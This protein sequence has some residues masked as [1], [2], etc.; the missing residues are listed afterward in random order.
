MNNSFFA[1]I[2][3]IRNAIDTH[4]LV[5]FAG[6]GISI[7]AGVP[8][9]STLIDEMRA[10]I[11]VPPN[12]NDYLRIAQMYFNDRQQKEYLEKIR[13]VLKHTKVKYN[14]IHEEIFDLNPEHILTT[15]YDDLLDQVIK[16]KSLPFSVIRKDHDFP[17]ALNTKH[18]VKI[19]G[20]LSENELVLKEDDYIDYSNEHPLIEGFIKS[21]FVSK[22]VLFIGYGFSDI[23]LK[24]IIQTVRNILGDDFQSAYLLNIDKNFH[25]VQRE[26]LK[27]KGIR[28]IN[29]HDADSKDGEN[30]IT[31]YL[32]GK[33]A[34]NQQYYKESKDLSEKGQTLL[35]FI[36][37]LT[38]Y[39]KFNEKVSSKNLI[40]QMLDSLERFSEFKSLPPN[41]IANLFPFNN[42]KKYVHHYERN[43]ILTKN[44]KL[45][46]LFFNHIGYNEEGEVIYTPPEDLGLT[47]SEIEY[48]QTKL[49]KVIKI[50]N[51]GLI[52][53]IVKENDTPDSFGYKGWSDKY[54]KL[55]VKHPEKCDCLSCCYNRLDLSNVISETAN[56]TIIE[57]SEISSD[58]QVAYSNYNLGNFLLSFHQF[59]EIA[60]K[61][62]ETGRY[63]SY[64]IAKHNSKTLHNLIS[65]FERTIEE[66]DKEEILKKTESI[67]FDKLL[68]QIPYMGEAEYRLL[69]IIRDDDVLKQAGKE[70]R[71]IHRKVIDTYELYKNGGAS[72]HGPNYPTQ[73]NHEL[74]KIKSFYISNHIVADAFTEFR[75]VCNIA[76]EALIICSAIKDEY[77]EKLKEFD[78]LFFET[79]VFYGN[80]TDLKKISEKYNVNSLNFAEKDR[81]KILE[82]TNNFLK[83]FVSNHAFM[84]IVSADD[85]TSVQLKNYFFQ[86]R[87]ADK[88]NN[89]F[90]QLS[91]MLIKI[92]ETGD[93][94]QNLISFL[95]I[96]DFIDNQGL[97]YLSAFISKNHHLFTRENCEA[98]LQKPMKKYGVDRGSKLIYALLQVYEKNKFSLS[99]QKDHLLELAYSKHHNYLFLPD[100]WS[101]STDEIKLLIKQ[102]ITELLNE[103]FN[104][105]LYVNSVVRGVM[106]YDSFFEKYISEINNTKGINGSVEE[107][108]VF[109]NAILFL[110]RMNIPVNQY[111][112]LLTNKT[113]YMDF[114]LDP[115]NYDY[116]GF[117]AE[118][119]TKWDNSIIYGRL[120]KIKGLK[121]EIE[122]AIKQHFDSELAEIY[123]KYFGNI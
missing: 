112:S 43:A 117:K 48:Y 102:R 119:I 42:S 5:V 67:D 19:H 59:E 69:K 98:I 90:L 103:K 70:L 106:P 99:N 110:Y 86:R 22:I 38:N 30:Y 78:L 114:Y 91:G 49:K 123:F 60:N 18:L 7:D 76:L 101:I 109:L 34:L 33:N 55:W 40:D 79:F 68:F 44:E 100:L 2:R 87:S 77:K 71:E 96:E 13:T 73:I 27:K 1:D 54:K 81:S 15:N 116:S 17:Y 12:E 56:E 20:D 115:E 75:E 113:A 36:R 105:D 80:A 94:I 97:K 53:Y 65:M 61:A 4:R 45:A 29:Y 111:L 74:H 24:M 118:W 31:S 58:I 10:D 95:T 83:S 66:K 26:Y 88:F 25:P 8:G 64:Y 50:L 21:M 120:G 72:Y 93:L 3:I 52:F 46:D 122:K 11:N 84:G 63:F 57:S 108:V 104:A 9:W 82:I 92:D 62:W 35:N 28:V 23:N 89:I 39:D 16:V 107:D 6:A 47:T 14:A 41:F 121:K 37:F 32:K 51:F 85:P